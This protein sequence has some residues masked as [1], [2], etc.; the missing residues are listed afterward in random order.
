MDEAG[1]ITVSV[2][3]AS[4]DDSEAE[5]QC[6]YRPDDP[7]YAEVVRHVSPINPGQTKYFT[8]PFRGGRPPNCD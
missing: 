1:V 3:S 4:S 2:R 8:R 6:T 7:E 5:D